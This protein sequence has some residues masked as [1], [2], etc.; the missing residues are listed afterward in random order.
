MTVRKPS[1]EVW[2]KEAS[3]GETAYRATITPEQ[4]LSARTEDGGVVLRRRNVANQHS[5]QQQQLQPSRHRRSPCALPPRNLQRPDL[6]SVVVG[7][8]CPDDYA[9]KFAP[10]DRIPETYFGEA[11]GTVDDYRAMLSTLAIWKGLPEDVRLQSSSLLGEKKRRS[12]TEARLTDMK[13][14]LNRRS[15]IESQHLKHYPEAS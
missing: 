1:K 3:F 7:L 14:L 10:K 9:N 13:R 8:R 4:L 15:R 2:I 12:D 6:D 11:A 5:L